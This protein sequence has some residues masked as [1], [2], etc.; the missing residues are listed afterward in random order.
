MARRMDAELFAIYVDLGQDTSDQD[1][2]S[3]NANL[4]FSKLGAKVVKLKGKD[5]PAPPR[6][7]FVKRACD[8]R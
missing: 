4:Q 8:V 6:N 3:L 7:S 1:R 2:N 5:L